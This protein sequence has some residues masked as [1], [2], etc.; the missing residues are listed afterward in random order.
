MHNPG[1]RPHP[2]AKLVMRLHVDDFIEIDECGKKRIMRVHNISEGDILI[3]D[4]NEADVANRRIVLQEKNKALRIHSLKRLQEFNA[5][6]IHISP[7]GKI[8]YEVRRKPRRK[9]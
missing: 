6:K 3:V 9:C 2:A 4:H 8:N 1:Y 5:R 7:T